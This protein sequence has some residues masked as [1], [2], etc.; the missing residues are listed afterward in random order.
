[1]AT[2]TQLSI[3]EYL[4]TSYRPDREY[5]DGELRERNVGKWEHARLQMVLGAWFY[6]H[7]SEWHITGSTE[8]RTKVA[9]KRVRIPDLVI[10]KA[11]RQPDVLV[12]P[13]LLIIEILSPDDTYSDTEERAADYQRMGVET[14]WIID[15]QTRTGRMCVGSSWTS[16]M[17]LEVP[18]TPIYVELA[19][20]FDQIN[21][22]ALAEDE[23]SA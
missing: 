15:P 10:L 8:Q 18:G 1:M 7:E 14:V 4:E 5:I 2:Q 20:M 3:S 11:G 16:A 21:P 9:G 13:P 23:P 12:D 22:P 19:A 6:N 17:R